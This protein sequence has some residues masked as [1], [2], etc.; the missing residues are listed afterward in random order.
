MSKHIHI[1]VGGSKTKDDSKEDAKA[2]LS[3][4]SEM[5][6]SISNLEAQLKSG[7]I[8][9]SAKSTARTLEMNAKTIS[10]DIA[11]ILEF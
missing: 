5:R 2:I 7:N 9:Q 6:S 4:L 11:H 3:V 8:S 1:H 10:Q